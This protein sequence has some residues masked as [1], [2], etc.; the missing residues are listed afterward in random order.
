MT[1][2]DTSV[3]QSNFKI[4]YADKISDNVP[5]FAWIMK[6]AEK[7]IKTKRLGL[8]YSQPV[9]L[10]S[11]QGYKFSTA[12]VYAQVDDY[13][14]LNIKTAVV[15]S[16]E[17]MRSDRIPIGA[18]TRSQDG[19]A[20][21][22]PVVDLTMEDMATGHYTKLEIVNL[23]GGVG[24]ATTSNTALDNQTLTSKIQ[25]TPASWA[26]GVWS[27]Q[28]NCKIQFYNSTS[29]VSSGADSIF[30][31]IDRDSANYTITVSGTSGGNSTLQALTTTP[32]TIY[33]NG[34]Y[35][36][37]GVGL[38]SIAANTGTLF[39]INAAAAGN[40]LWKGNTYDC[41]SGPV[42]FAK[43][44]KAAAIAA[45]NGLIDEDAVVLVSSASWSDLVSSQA[46]ARRYVDV[47]ETL[48]NGA[49][50]LEF[51]SSVGAL[52]IVPHP[53][54]KRGEAF[55]FPESALALVGST[56]VTYDVAGESMFLR[57]AGTNSYEA[58]S[59][60]DLTLFSDVPAKMVV[61]TSIVPNA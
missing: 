12:G 26:A 54:I 40:S 21:F 11:G 14:A 32:L 4:R 8:Q 52:K 44:Q 37:E 10:A 30:Q 1:D 49:R 41:S 28:Q 33:F 42:T 31:V 18:I 13:V 34:A 29:L 51:V 22:S 59:Y 50:A 2:M 45:D 6:N 60:S 48:V 35:G 20:A 24:L 23:Y 39:T 15:S 5:R 58:A 16:Y 46:A 27:S 7:L 56:D 3:L 47:K 55:L 61:L 57:I 53:C 38:R 9:K 19:Q 43:L 25:I 36:V 17:L